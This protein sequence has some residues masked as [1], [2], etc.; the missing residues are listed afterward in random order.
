MDKTGTLELSEAEEAAL[1]E[2]QAEDEPVEEPEEEEGEEPSG[3][4][5][6]EPSEEP[7]EEPEKAEKQKTVPHQALHEERERRKQVEDELRQAREERARF[8]ERL[9]I[10]QEMNQRQ[11]QQPQEVEEAPDWDLNPI[12]AG[13]YWERKLRER[14]QYEQQQRAQY[15]QQQRQQQEWQQVYD[16]ALNEWNGYKEQNP[17]AEDAY[18]HLLQ[19][20]AKEFEYAG[21]AP[22]E[23]AAAIHQDEAKTM[24]YARQKGI[25]LSKLVVGMAQARGWQPKAKESE[26]SDAEERVERVSNGQSRNKSLSQAG[27]QAAPSEMTADRL[28]KMSNEE[29]DTWCGKHP[30][31]AAKLMGA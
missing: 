11:Q 4:P 16:H 20:R 10:I 26:P 24:L 5:E 2:M 13:K 17:D 25:P 7:A 6:E 12:E 18:Q 28:L 22:H 19:S 3:E 29:F 23:I 15:E 30:K 21:Y 31:Q 14:E 8:D 1:A 27:G 9:R